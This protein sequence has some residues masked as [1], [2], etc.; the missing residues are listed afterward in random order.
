MTTLK[1]LGLLL[2]T[3]LRASLSLRGAFLL[4]AAFM[5]LNNLVYFWV[6]VVFFKRFHDLG[7]FGMVDMEL[8]YGIVACGF[9]LAVTL[10]GGLR[11]L[12]RMIVEGALD[13]YLT[14]PKPA[15]LQA[16]CSRT[17]ASGWGDLASGLLMIGLSHQVSLVHLP[18]LLLAIV[19]SAVVFVG[20]GV[21]FHSAAFWLGPVD[22]LA[23][24]LWDFLITFSIYP[25][26]IFGGG[27][28]ILLFTLMPAAFSGFLPARLAH[29][30]TP[31]N[32]ALALGGAVGVT[33]VALVVFERGLRRYESGNQ[34]GVR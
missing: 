22:S 29:Q 10:A 15:L 5:A 16:L 6:W 31:L 1:Y 21:F 24:M 9:G 18:Y 3:N 33:C 32:L 11:E 20:A 25:E 26:P 19:L 34:I 7:G 30:P 13:S 4:Q 8:T 14:Q 23:R 12:S 28:R 17:L 27:I 2:L